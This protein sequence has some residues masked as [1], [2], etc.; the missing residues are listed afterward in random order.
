MGEITGAE[1]IQTKLTDFILFKYH[2]S[3]KIPFKYYL[4]P[5]ISPTDHLNKKILFNA[6][7]YH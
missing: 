4:N 5:K 1:Q 7:R 3:Q 2:L 6:N